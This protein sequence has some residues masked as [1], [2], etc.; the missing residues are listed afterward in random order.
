LKISFLNLYYPFNIN[1]KVPAYR[2]SIGELLRFPT[3]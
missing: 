1:I 3:T 2:L